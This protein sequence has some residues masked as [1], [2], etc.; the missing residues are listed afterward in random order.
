MEPNTWLEQQLWEFDSKNQ[1]GNKKRKNP[2]ILSLSLSF[3]LP[4]PVSH[5]LPLSA[6]LSLQLTNSLLLPLLAKPKL[7][8]EELE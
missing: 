1:P 5:S 3:A 7:R 6:S 4:L 2:S 8:M